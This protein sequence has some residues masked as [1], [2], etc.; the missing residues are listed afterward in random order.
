MEVN[1][2]NLPIGKY[3]RI[4]EMLSKKEDDIDAHASILA[5]IY[6]MNVN[7][8]LDLPLQKYS[9]MS[10]SIAFLHERIGHVK[11]RVKDCY[12]IGDLELIPTKDAKK[13]T[14]SQYIDY[15]TFL[16][17]ENA[18]VELVSTLLVP[19]GCRYGVGYDMA[20]VYKAVGMLSVLDVCEMSAFFLQ[21]FQDSISYILICL[22]LKLRMTLPRKEKKKIME[23]LR[24]VRNSVRS[25]DGFRMC[26]P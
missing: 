2:S 9:E 10:E 5:I 11:P 12:K 14:A 24:Q 7:E 23:A 4:L 15:Q 1:Y 17:R 21:K 26:I 3:Q 16:K 8:V 6:D 19:K 20:D 25:G 22:E 18:M 13:F